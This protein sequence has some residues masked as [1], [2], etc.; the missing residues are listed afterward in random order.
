MAGPEIAYVRGNPRVAYH[1]AV[2]GMYPFEQKITATLN[3]NSNGVFTRGTPFWNYHARASMMLK[4]GARFGLHLESGYRWINLK[5][6]DKQGT[7]F[8]SGGGELNLSGPFIGVGFIR[9]F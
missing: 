5:N 1:F 9:F 3:N 8:I 7:P 2:G 6:L 4:M